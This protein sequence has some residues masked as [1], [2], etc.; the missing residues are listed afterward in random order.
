MK[1]AFISIRP[2]HVENIVSGKKTVEIR[3]V[4]LNL[5][6]GQTIWIYA[7][8]PV[9]NLVAV[10]QVRAIYRLAPAKIWHQFKDTVAITKQEFDIYVGDRDQITAIQLSGVR[11]LHKPMSLD[12]LRLKQPRF[13][14]PQVI[15]YFEEGEPI[16]KALR[17]AYKDVAVFR[18]TTLNPSD[19]HS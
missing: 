12:K 3:T 16:L 5:K 15:R 4:N 17:T 8:I 7:T 14:P 9:A 10:A 2:K 13:Q 6:P 18:Q 11:T 1:H 19:L